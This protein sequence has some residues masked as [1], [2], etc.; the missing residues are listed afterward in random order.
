MVAF[1]L[2][3]TDLALAPIAPPPS[4]SHSLSLS[5]LQ[6]FS[7]NPKASRKKVLP[8]VKKLFAHQEL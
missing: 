1:L 3:Q 5:S 7:I 8:V 6:L 4:P 2:D